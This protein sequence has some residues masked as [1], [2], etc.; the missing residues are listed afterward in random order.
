M[1]SEG[2]PVLTYPHSNYMISQ[3][4]NVREP[5]CRH[6]DIWSLQAGGHS[7]VAPTVSY[8]L[9]TCPPLYKEGGL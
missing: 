6:Q 5:G 7:P 1:R 8:P 3:S 4:S 9:Y 2:V